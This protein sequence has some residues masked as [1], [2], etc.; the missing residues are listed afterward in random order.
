VQPAL[1]IEGEEE[2]GSPNLERFM[3]A[4]PEAFE[5]D[6][7]VLTD[8]EN[9]STGDPGLTISLRGLIEVELK[10]ETH[11]A[12]VHSG[13]GAT[14]CPTR[15]RD[16]EARRAAHRRGRAPRLGRQEVPSDWREASLERAAR[17]G[18]GPREREALDGVSRCQPAVD[19]PPSGCGVSPP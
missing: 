17:R 5:S 6:V 19:R 4:F 13:S 15:H 9:P 14:S 11:R 1:L 8:C 12:D 2:I 18:G 3:D 7:M 10:C 16:D